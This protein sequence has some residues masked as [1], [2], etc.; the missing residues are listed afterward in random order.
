MDKHKELIQKAN[1]ALGKNLMPNLT[2]KERHEVQTVLI[3]VV[4]ELEHMVSEANNIPNLCHFGCDCGDLCP[5]ICPNSH[6]I[7]E[8]EE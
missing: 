1:A 5:S 2:T 8:G 6:D 3:E 4:S 7:E